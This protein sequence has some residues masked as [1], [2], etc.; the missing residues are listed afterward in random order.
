MLVEVA[1][2]EAGDFAVRDSVA[3]AVAVVAAP[4]VAHEAIRML[5]QILPDFRMLRQVV[6]EAR[7]RREELR[8]VRQRRIGAQLMRHFRMFIEVAVVEASDRPL[9]SAPEAIAPAKA[10]AARAVSDFFMTDLLV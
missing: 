9:S 7:M 1:V 3:A 8:V 6:V 4:F 2:V 5:L 10:S